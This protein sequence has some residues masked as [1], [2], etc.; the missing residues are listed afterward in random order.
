MPEISMYEVA[1][2]GWNEE[3][4]DRYNPEPFWERYAEPFSVERKWVEPEGAVLC[5]GGGARVLIHGDVSDGAI[6]LCAGGASTVEVM[7]SVRYGA[8]ILAAGGSARVIVHGSV[9]PTAQVLARGGGATTTI[10][11]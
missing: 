3:M 8:K 10:K 2:I 11:G 4:S 5:S 9:H 6:V 1:T 7:G